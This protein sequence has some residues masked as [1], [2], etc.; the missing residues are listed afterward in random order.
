MSTVDVLAIGESLGLVVPESTGRLAHARGARVGFGGAESNVA[1]GVARLGGAAAWTGRVG[2]D[3]LGEL[4]VREIRAE[5]VQVH[6]VVDAEAATALM[7]KE[8]PRPGSSRVT[9]YRSVQAGSRLVPSDIAPGLVERAR[10][11][12]VT[13][14]SAGLGESPLS[15][16]HEAVERARA[17]GVLV[18]FDV[19]HRS[20][21]W[22]DGRDARAAYRA[23]AAR[24]DVVFAGDDEAELLTGERGARAQLDAIRALGP[25]CAVVKRGSAGAIADEDGEIVERDALRVDVVDTVGA[26]DAFVAGW[27]AETAVGATLN[28]RIDTAVACGAAACTGA[29]D[30]EASPTRADLSALAA[31]SGDPVQ[32]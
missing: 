5:G 3:G 32:R 8:R 2:A 10:I 16:V 17:A 14:I 18:S 27:L 29:G 31:P 24:A 21:L 19:N 13:G 20:A 1:I 7:I 15:A 12:H 28:T 22:R 23:L 4:I 6:A 25:R 26:G 9:Y 11:V 30:W